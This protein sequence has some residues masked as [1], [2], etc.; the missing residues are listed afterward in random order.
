MRYLLLLLPLLLMSCSSQQLEVVELPGDSPLVTFRVTFLTGS[1]SDPADKPGLANLTASMISDGGTAAMSYQDL[2]AA[3]FPM[4]T[5]VSSQVDK[6]MTTFSAVT[7]IDN[8]DRFYELFHAMLFAPGWRDED[9]S[10]LRD[11]T[12]NYLRVSLRGNNDE[13]LGKEYL[14]NLIY[15]G[16][17]YG[18]DNAGTVSGLEAI[19]MEDIRNFYADHY[20]QSN[21]ILGVAGGYPPEFLGRLRNDFGQL[22]VGARHTVERPEPHPIDVTRSDPDYLPLL[23]ME[24]YFGPHRNSGGRLFQRMR[25]DRGLNYGDYVYTEYFPDGMFLFEPAPNLA[26]PQQIFQI[27]IRPV[28]PPTA[29]FALRLAMYELDKLIKEGISEEDFERTRTYLTKYVNLLLKT[30]NAEL[31]YAIDSR[32]YGIGEYAD[33]VKNGLAELTVDDVNRAIREHLH[34]DDLYIAVVAPNTEE[35]KEE[36][37]SGAPSPMVYNSPKPDEILEEDKTVEKWEIPVASVEIVPVDEV[38]E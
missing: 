33:F 10:R 11:Q 20:T 18:H 16:H 12:I 9:L 17:P 29:H 14:Y 32:Y 30:K 7:H 26:R 34:T 23:V 3:M 19:T 8:L 35:L 5:S 25:A 27:W 6:E 37:T 28:E 24:G 15:E 1:A 22:P 21:L 31:G 36:F 2:L 4:A 13:E 38:F